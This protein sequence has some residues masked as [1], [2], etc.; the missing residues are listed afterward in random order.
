M[1]SICRV[2]GCGKLTDRHYAV[3]CTGHR[4]R[5]RLHGDAEQRTL[6]LEM[7]APYVKTVEDRIK[8]NPKSPLWGLLENAWAQLVRQAEEAV[9]LKEA[10]PFIA[11]RVG[12]AEFLLQVARQ[13]TAR[14]VYTRVLACCLMRDREP[15]FFH[16]PRGFAFQMTRMVRLLVELEAPTYWDHKHQRTR[17]VYKVPN[18]KATEFSAALLTQAF[19][20]AGLQ[21]AHQE[22]ERVEGPERIKREIGEAIAALR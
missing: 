14:E 19:G 22:R 9:A 10:G 6:R 13:S 4:K 7:L 1:K 20:R 12:A 8:A 3:H 16:S 11:Y 5:H 2:P 17:R 18:Q 15:R 21:F